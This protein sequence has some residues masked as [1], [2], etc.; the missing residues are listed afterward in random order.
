MKDETAGR[1]DGFDLLGKRFE[2]DLALFEFCD[3]ADEVGEVPAKPVEPPDNK[4]ILLSQ[5]FEAPFQLGSA[6][7]LSAGPFFVHLT[8]FG[9]LEGILLQVESLVVGRDTGV[10]DSHVSNPT[11]AGVFRT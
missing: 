11:K 6:G 1:R 10:A 8:A 3:E 9:V 5:A 4:G 2:V 7:V